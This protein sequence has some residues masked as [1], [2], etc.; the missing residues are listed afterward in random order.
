[1]SHL[2]D[3]LCW[4][5]I[6]T[7]TV[8]HTVNNEAL[9]VK[10]YK[11]YCED[12]LL[13]YETVG[14]GENFIDHQTGFSKDIYYKISFVNSDGEES[15]FSQVKSIRGNE[16]LN[17]IKAQNVTDLPTGINYADY[18]F[19]SQRFNRIKQRFT[20][21]E[22]PSL[23]NGKEF[24]GGLYWNFYQEVINDNIG[25][26]FG[27]QT[28]VN[29]DP[30][31]VLSKGII[32]SRWETRDVSNYRLVNGGWAESSGHEGDFIGI[33]K[34]YEWGVGT[35]EIELKLVETDEIGDW[36]GLFIK[37]ISSE[38][39]TYIGSIRFDHGSNE[40]I[41]SGAG[42]WTEI[43][44]S[45][46]TLEFP[47]WHVS[48]DDVKI[49]NDEQPIR[50]S[51]RY[52]EEVWQSN[53]LDNHTNIF[54]PDGK[55]VHFLMGP[56]VKRYHQS[57]RNLVNTETITENECDYYKETTANYDPSEN[58][59]HYLD[60]ISSED[61]DYNFSLLSSVENLSPGENSTP[62]TINISNCIWS[63][64][65]SDSRGNIVSSVN[66]NNK[67]LLLSHEGYLTNNG[68][69][70]LPNDNDDF[71]I[72]FIGNNKNV[73]LF[74]PT[75][76]NENNLSGFKSKVIETS[77][78]SLVTYFNPNEIDQVNFN[79]YDVMVLF[80]GN[81]RLTS[82]QTS[83]IKSFV[84]N[85]QKKTVLIGVGWVWRDYYANNNEEPMP[86]NQ[87]LN[88]SGAEFNISQKNSS[89]SNI[90]DDTIFFPDTTYL[91]V[92]HIC[93]D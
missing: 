2:K 79:Q 83:K 8:T 46:S 37:N 70:D 3:F 14:I 1:M 63:P 85:E 19:S 26:Y 23:E 11:G 57:S 82:I 47:R 15:N 68:M 54:S 28:K 91:I 64:L 65:F 69:N 29:L 13:L 77:N 17:S 60:Y 56:F 12:N 9:N 6:I 42:S 5:I 7:I 51:S 39:Y 4:R 53:Q 75:F 66:N 44:D 90:I 25:F 41:L 32:F 22:L 73:L 93:S 43:Y 20:I 84:E 33:R 76:E 38:D 55:E 62:G 10:I 30:D 59:Y 89:P 27:L 74:F 40:G 24:D 88:N 67:T 92:N 48:I 78:S 16:P 80:L 18:H 81:H 86:M 21:H 87:I 71:L 58:I 52:F 31:G 72:N 36:Y 50:I 61:R 45:G 34:E 49:N 35:Y